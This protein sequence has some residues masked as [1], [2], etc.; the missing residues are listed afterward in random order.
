M[1]KKLIAKS[2]AKAQEAESSPETIT[3]AIHIPKRT[4]TLLRAVAFYR[5]QQDGGRASVSKVIAML[6]ED[7]RVE[8]EREVKG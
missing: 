4:W 3:T 5:A 2:K 1:A 6:A 7:R 8:L